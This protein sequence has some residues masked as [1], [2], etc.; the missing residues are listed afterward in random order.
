MPDS[1]FYKSQAFH[2]STA[3]TFVY[4]FETNKSSDEIKQYY[5]DEVRKNQWIVVSVSND[6]IYCTKVDCKLWVVFKNPNIA[7]QYHINLG[8][9]P[10]TINF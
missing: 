10:R 7:G 5:L 2:K 1:F 4:F 8:W 9:P 6:T 3:V